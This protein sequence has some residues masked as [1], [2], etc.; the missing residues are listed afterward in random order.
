MK[1]LNNGTIIE[2]Q[3]PIVQS[4]VKNPDGIAVDWI[5]NHLYWTDAGYDKIEVTNYDGTMRKT[6]I[7]SGL[8]EPRAIV[9]DPISGYVVLYLDLN[10]K[11]IFLPENNFVQHFSIKI[12]LLNSRV[13]LGEIVIVGICSTKLTITKVLEN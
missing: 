3:M 7:Q 11:K 12:F 6:L 5:Y 1:R 2:D 13:R 8:D 9:V 10:W 4:N